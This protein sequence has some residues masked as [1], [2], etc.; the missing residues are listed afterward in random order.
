M[1]MK[2]IAVQMDYPSQ[3]RPSGDSTICLIE[4]AQARG[5][6]VYIY[7]PSSLAYHAGEVRASVQRMTLGDLSAPDWYQLQPAQTLSLSGMDVVLMRQDP[8]FDMHYLTATY[9]LEQI[10]GDARVVNDPASVRSYPEKLLP[11]LYAEAM[12]ETTITPH[13]AD[14]LEALEQHGDIIVKPLFGWGGHSVLRLRRES[15]N[16]EALLEMVLAPNAGKP[17]LPVM[18]QPFLPEV[19]TQDI[20]VV[21]IAGEIAGAFARTPAQGEIRANMRVGGVPVKV[22]L[23]KKQM[24]LCE[25]MAETLDAM[26]IMIA[27]V[28]FIGEYVTEINV[29]SPTGLRTIAN[30]YG[31]NPAALFWDAVE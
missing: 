13:R 24:S 21:L 31:T 30:L 4:E 6:E 7:H 28:D 8:P 3:L 14:I 26:G 19:A 12:P 22:K 17:P 18:V 15:D 1:Y 11:L 5:M 9:L 10:G 23:S 2:K 20:R 16:V 29:T 27:G 25:E